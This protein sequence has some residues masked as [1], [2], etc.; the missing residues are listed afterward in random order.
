MLKGQMKIP[1][2]KR[3]SLCP[4]EKSIKLYVGSVMEY[5]FLKYFFKKYILK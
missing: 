3:E 4:L 5:V 2:T 1:P